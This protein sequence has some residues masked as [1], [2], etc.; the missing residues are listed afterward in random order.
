MPSRSF[1][2]AAIL[3]SRTSALV[4]VRMIRLLLGSLVRALIPTLNKLGA[5][6]FAR[7]GT[8]NHAVFAI[9]MDGLARPSGGERAGC[10]ALP[11][12]AL[13]PD[14][15]DLDRAVG[16]GERAERSPRFDGLQLL[17]VTNQ[18]DLRARIARR[19]QHPL[20]LAR[21]RQPASSMTSTSRSLNCS[22]PCFH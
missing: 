19:R 8:V 17:G 13:P 2:R 12:V 21:S 4:W 16:L 20:H 6:S 3:R 15:G 9:G 14:L 5:R 1:S 10:T 11:V 18:H 7:L 22:R